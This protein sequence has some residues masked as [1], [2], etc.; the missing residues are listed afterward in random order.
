M[1]KPLHPAQK[2]LNHHSF[3]VFVVTA[4]AMLTIVI[5]L[6]YNTFTEATTPVDVESK[7]NVPTSF[8]AVTEKKLESL[9]TRK[10]QNLEVTLP[11]DTRVNPFV[12]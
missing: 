7:V 12:E 3:V 5:A 2:F 1:S 9:H 10:D 4:A 11:V 6:C 8:D